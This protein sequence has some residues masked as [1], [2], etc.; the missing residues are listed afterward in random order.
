MRKKYSTVMVLIL[1]VLLSGCGGNRIGT[2]ITS[3]NINPVSQKVIDDIAAL[4][5]ITVDDEEAIERI[6]E[7]YVTLTDEQK[8]QVSNY[9]DLLNAK[10]TIRELR[11][12]QEVA[13]KQKF[14]KSLEVQRLYYPELQNAI[15]VFG[16][17]LKKRLTLEV[18]DIVVVVYTNDITTGTYVTD[19][20]A[21]SS[22]I[23][24]GIYYSAENGFG[25]QVTGEAR[26]NKL[27]GV[28]QWSVNEFYSNGYQDIADMVDG[29]NRT[30]YCLERED[31]P[32]MRFEKL[33][34]VEKVYF[35]LDMKDFIE[36]GYTIE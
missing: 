18:F 5:D 8:N 29:K 34:T 14:S 28:N 27:N 9:I 13:E 31:Y 20:S 12:N 17:N 11:A 25:T 36:Q 19:M 22:G 24:M 2:N 30:E 23:D 16:K 33:V 7:L 21:V 32:G 35:R 6:E 26:L 1:C 3:K 15:N 4:G 10:D